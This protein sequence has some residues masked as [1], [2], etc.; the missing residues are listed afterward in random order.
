M[1]KARKKV[2]VLPNRQFISLKYTEGIPVFYENPRFRRL[3][4]DLQSVIAPYRDDRIMHKNF[5]AYYDKKRKE[6][7]FMEQRRNSNFYKV[8]AKCGHVGRSRYCLKPFYVK[9]PD[10]RRAAEIVRN[11]SRVKH[12][13]KDAIKD[14]VE[15]SEAEYSTGL[16]N[17][18]R[19]PY[20]NCSN[21]QEQGRNFD[22]IAGYVFE[23]ARPA[24]Y[25][26][27]ESRKKRITL[28]LKAARKENKYGAVA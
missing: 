26:D 2:I 25:A 10:G 18:S 1:E 14:V 13:H 24:A 11:A 23:E 22:R 9:A 6:R 27:G 3:A 21:V 15:I 16:R 28:R 5:Y 8:I 19:D 12:D 7:V 17:N 20:F 4:Q